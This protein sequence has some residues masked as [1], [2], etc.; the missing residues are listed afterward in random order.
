[1][2][3]ELGVDR[4]YD[5]KTHQSK[6]HPNQRRLNE[7]CKCESGIIGRGFF[8]RYDRNRGPNR[9][10]REILLGPFSTPLIFL[11]HTIFL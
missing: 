8:D 10:I 1:M 6:P 7:T 2:G 3:Y 5:T 9:K 4:N 11:G